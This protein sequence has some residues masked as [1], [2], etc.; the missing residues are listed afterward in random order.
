MMK[1]LLYAVFSIILLSQ[2]VTADDESAAEEFI[3][4]NLD[5]VFAVLQNSDLSQ[6]AK[7]SQVEKI[8][9]PMFDF[10][11]MAKLSLGRKH[12]PNLSQDQR[13][14]FTDLF[15]ERLRQSYLNKLTSYT[16]EKIIYESPIAVKKKIHVPTLLISKGKKISMLYKLY[17]NNNTWKIYDVEIQG[18]SIIRSYRAQFNEI[19]QNGTFDDLLQKM[20]KPANN[21]N[22]S[23]K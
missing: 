17:P 4:S 8:A 16:D 11:R 2:A 19:L 7:D 14:R 10:K 22:P 13:E 15:V 18:V 12:W 9:T 5:A 20:Q 6:Q 23:Q 3:K 1:V 21:S